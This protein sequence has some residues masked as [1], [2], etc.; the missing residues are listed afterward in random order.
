ME[1]QLIGHLALA[2]ALTAYEL[3]LK[4]PVVAVTELIEQGMGLLV[5]RASELRVTS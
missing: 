3:W 4:D 1:P 5:E 2:V